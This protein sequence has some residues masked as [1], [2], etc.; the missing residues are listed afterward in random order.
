MSR[1]QLAFGTRIGQGERLAEEV[2][3]VG[4]VQLLL[5]RVAC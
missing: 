3:F 2:P 1:L 4:H 5:E